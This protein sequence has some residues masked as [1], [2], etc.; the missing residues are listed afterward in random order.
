MEKVQLI[1]SDAWAANGQLSIPL[2]SIPPLT[3]VRGIFLDIDG[4]YT[5]DGTANTTA[6]AV[7]LA[8][9][10]V[11][12]VRLDKYVN[13]SAYDL[14]ELFL[15]RH[16][17]AFENLVGIAVTKSATATFHVTIPIVWYHP[18]TKDEHCMPAELLRNKSLDL[19]LGAGVPIAHLTT[20]LCTIRT[21]VV[22]VETTPGWVPVVTEMGAVDFGGQS[23]IL[24]DRRAYIDAYL[25][26]TTRLAYG[27]GV[28]TAV[29]VLADGNSVMSQLA[30]Q[31]IQDRWN[32]KAL[33]DTAMAKVLLDRS[34]PIITSGRAYDLT[35][36][37]FAAQSLQVNISGTLT[38]PHMVY[39][40]A[41]E[42]TM[43]DVREI[44]RAT[45]IEPDAATYSLVTK[46]HGGL[47]APSNSPRA[48]RFAGLLAGRWR[49]RP[50]RER[51]VQSSVDALQ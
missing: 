4:T 1:R 38:T 9:A 25:A 23:I 39:Y 6:P 45:G 12:N 49:G 19:T 26:T 40:R 11:T 31:Q 15:N 32:F 27:A 17:R 34:V 16:G 47:K 50:Q 14:Q 3:K 41:I 7:D 29:E 37:P 20:S 44:G 24:G 30:T 5:E 2:T 36:V 21:S 13:L 46:K 33:V 48:A 43:N 35:K 18:G 10:C 42:K 28:L 51:A 22:C 8:A